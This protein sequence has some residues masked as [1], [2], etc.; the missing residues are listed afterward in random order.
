MEIGLKAFVYFFYTSPSENSFSSPG[1]CALGSLH[2]FHELHIANDKANFAED[3]LWSTGVFADESSWLN[4]TLSFR[5]S[6][7]SLSTAP[8]PQAATQTG[9]GWW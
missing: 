4:G 6:L 5:T 9:L 8:A 3:D 7:P 1:T 2:R